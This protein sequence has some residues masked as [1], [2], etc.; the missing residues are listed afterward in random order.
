MRFK[1]EIEKESEEDEI[2]VL[3]EELSSDAITE[4]EWGF[5]VGYYGE[6]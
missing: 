4:E 3:D 5:S 2:E 6:I 1:R